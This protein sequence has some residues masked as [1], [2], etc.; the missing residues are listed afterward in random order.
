MKT[1]FDEMLEG[2]KK[3]ME[4][5]QKWS[6]ESMENW[7]KA[8]GPQMP[9]WNFPGMNGAAPKSSF[10]RPDMQFWYKWL[11]DSNAWI[12]KNLMERIPLGMQPHY[13]SFLS[14]YDELH[15]YWEP[16]L[17]M[18]QHGMV[19]RETADQYFG[20]E[21]YKNFVSRFMGFKPVTNYSEM[22]EQ[23]NNF[24]EGYIEFL[25]NFTPGT[26]DF[27]VRMSEF[28]RD[29]GR[30]EGN[31][32]FQ[33]IFE[34]TDMVQKGMDS[35]YHVAGPS[36][37]I[38]M[39]RIVKD[40]QF[41]YIAFITKSADMQS[42]L[43]QAGQFAL[44][45][46]LKE[47]YND[48]QKTQKLPEYAEFFNRYVNNLEGYLLEVLESD[49]YSKL[50]SEVAKMGV[51]VKSKMD[52]MFEL[53]FQN[54]PFLLKSHADEVALELT[55]L[56]RRLRELEGRLAELEG[57]QMPEKKEAPASRTRKTTVK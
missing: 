42:E 43:M 4:F 40:M 16:F 24:F 9:K 19:G 1:G 7:T 5:W 25:R 46:T 55:A 31:P 53:A 12:Q 14:S 41:A 44:P 35:L 47:F 17:Q 8:S 34:V 22:I 49:K 57:E 27:S 6:S 21:A 2:Q 33:S 37:E 36:E 26:K 13:E 10:F 39:A 54:T 11:E 51:M 48:F 20:P 52:E 18:I 30:R 23:S 32:M 3:L 15:K 29:L 45:D 56:R 28:F 38:Q 50:Q